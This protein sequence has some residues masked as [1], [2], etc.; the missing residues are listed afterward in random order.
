MLVGLAAISAVATT[1]MTITVSR[2]SAAQER[3]ALMTGLKP[4]DQV[5]VSRQL[6]WTIAV[7]QAYQI[8]WTQL[9]YFSPWHQTPQPGSTVVEVPWAGDSAAQSWPNPPAGWHVD[10]ASQSG[11]WVSWRDTP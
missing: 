1:Q 4:S 10:Q 5:S 9:G 2:A 8:W 11:G 6:S 3:P 7:P